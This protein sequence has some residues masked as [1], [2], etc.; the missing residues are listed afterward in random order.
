[1]SS[2]IKKISALLL[3]LS[4]QTVP[5]VYAQSG[6]DYGA[7]LSELENLI[8]RCTEK[9]IPVDYEKVNYNVISRFNEYIN[10]DIR[11]GVDESIVSY[12]ISCLDS[13][14]NEAKSNLEAYLSGRKVPLSV[15]EKDMQNI[16]ASGSV[17]KDGERPVFSLGFGHAEDVR[18]DIKLLGDIGT[19][20]IQI[21]VG[22]R[23]LGM[24]VYGFDTTYYSDGNVE[25]CSEAAKSGVYGLKVD[26]YT[27]KALNTAIWISQMVPCEP[28]A[29][30]T[31]SYD[32]R[33]VSGTGD[34]YGF[35][36]GVNDSTRNFIDET[37]DEWQHNE[38]TY[39]APAGKNEMK[40]QITGQDLNT[41]Y[42]DNICI[43]DENGNVVDVINSGFE[44]NDMSYAYSI[45][46]VFDALEKAEENNMAVSLNLSPHYFP[47]NLP[48]KVYDN[49]SGGFIKYNI[50]EPEAWSVIENYINNL[51]PLLKGYP[52]LQNICLSN[53]PDYDTR[54]FHDFYNP[55]FREFLKTKHGNVSALN[56]AYGSS[57]EDFEQITMP[58]NG[59]LQ[60]PLGYDW[61][62]F[63]DSVFTAWHKK[64]A[65]LVHKHMP[66]IPVHSKMQNYFYVKDSH[67][68]LA[69]G[70]D[71]EMFDTFSDYAGNDAL[72][73]LE[74]K[75]R[76]YQTMF[77]YDYQMSVTD[78]PVYNSEDHIISDKNPDFSENQ[79]K[80]WRNNLWMGAVHG[81]SMS[82][83]WAWQRTEDLN[84]TT[85]FSA[86]FRP[87]CVSETGR[88]SLDLVRLSDEVTELQQ[89]NNDVAIFYSKPSRLY[90][91]PTYCAGLLETYKALIEIGIRPGVI[92]DKSIN[93]LSDY[94]TVVI[95]KA[96]N[97]HPE[98]LDAVNEFIKGG[99]KVI[100]QG[101]VFSKNQYNQPLDNAYIKENGVEYT[102]AGKTEITD[103]SVIC[104]ELSEALKDYMR[105]T[106]VDEDTGEAPTDIDFSYSIENGRLLANITNLVYD[107]V[108]NISVYLDGRK[109]SGMT[110]LISGESG[111]DIISADEYTPVLISYIIQKPVINNFSVD[112]SDG[113]IS[114][115]YVPGSYWGADIYKVS[116]KGE[117]DFYERCEND[118]YTLPEYGSW[119]IKA[120][121]GDENGSLISVFENSPFDV[122][123]RN[124]RKFGGNLYADIEIKNIC[125][126]YARAEIRHQI[127]DSDGNFYGRTSNTISLQA[128]GKTDIQLSVPTGDNFGKA[129]L[130]V[131]D[132]HG[133]VY[134]EE[135]EG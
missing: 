50:D 43:K 68:N 14:Y 122:N 15:P 22:P 32:A 84:S 18:K 6:V 109:L 46:Y 31:V 121:Y 132:T 70:K 123:V 21:E 72:D 2:V 38:F 89:N 11:S 55:K 61:I 4:V 100:Y 36:V 23:K 67:T 128:G 115:E 93:Q 53:E 76:Y 28:S 111:I 99:G 104:R 119:Y 133:N 130:Y 86:A 106:L 80:H 45:R 24:G 58:S 75:N 20:N 83:I 73:Y 110:D 63:N 37:T 51:M 102:S 54:N 77:L 33:Y 47:E 97:C 7:E 3:V 25:I 13:L 81:R 127:Y 92:S 112:K 116:G 131:L 48:E 66:E 16:T 103:T 117:L 19:D 27:K 87:D 125:G 56:I 94:E 62:E 113:V 39:K 82:T 64:M 124:V 8:E 29:V 78:K 65:D 26:T 135:K 9:G 60:T 69:R 5:G 44:N 129:V 57:Y 96:A 98:T 114:W 41:V 91:Y 134:Y 40:L 126:Q 17:L 52:A 105:V 71:V 10:T 88:T 120:V 108:K 118:Y 107:S 95:P 59:K 90:N 79:R 74:D 30:Y 12:N 34:G 35:W 101:N 42:V 1:M 85:Y 49:D